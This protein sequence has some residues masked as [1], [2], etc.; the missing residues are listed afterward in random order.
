MIEPSTTGFATVSPCPHCG[1]EAAALWDYCPSCGKCLSTASTSYSTNIYYEDKSNEEEEPSDLDEWD[2][3]RNQWLIVSE[4]LND[5]PRPKAVALH[6]PPPQAGLEANPARAPPLG[7]TS[8][9]GSQRLDNR[10]YEPAKT[11][12][13]G[14]LNAAPYCPQ[15]NR[16]RIFKA[17]FRSALSV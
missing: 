8:E 6:Q 7:Y 3:L 2:W 14:G 10:S 12:R 4:A 5:C 1:C 17:A 16:S 9:N 15:T 13:S 11:C